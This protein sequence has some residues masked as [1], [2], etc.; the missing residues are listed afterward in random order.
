MNDQKIASIKL[1]TGEEIVCNLLRLE[2]NDDFTLLSFENPLKI[3]YKE[4][5]KNYYLE[6]WLCVN[7]NSVHEI[8]VSKIITVSDISD[9]NILSDYFSFFKKEL[10]L[11]PKPKRPRRLKGSDSDPHSKNVSVGYLGNVK[12]IR[13]ELER[14]YKDTDSYERPKEL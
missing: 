11:K 2:V 13:S 4:T 6:P 14:L 3:K 5:N 1:I 10:E 8:E 7:N 9:L 12:D